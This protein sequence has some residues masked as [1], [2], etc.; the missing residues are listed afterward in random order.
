M[1]YYEEISWEYYI[2]SDKIK[3]KYWPFL[4]IYVK[5]K[6][7]WKFLDKIDINKYPWYK[8]SIWIWSNKMF[9]IWIDWIDK[10]IE[11]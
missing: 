1:F 6:I 11:I 10:V 3:W 8:Y 4:W 2:W 9:V 7:H 5:N